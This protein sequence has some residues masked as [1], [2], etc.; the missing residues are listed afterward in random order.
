MYDIYNGIKKLSDTNKE[1]I[2]TETAALDAIAQMLVPDKD[3][4]DTEKIK[5]ISN[6][7]VRILKYNE[8]LANDPESNPEVAQELNNR[9]IKYALSSLDNL[10]EVCINYACLF[11]ALA[12]R[13]GL[14]SKQLMASAHTWNKVGEDHIDLTSLDGATFM[15][16]KD[17]TKYSLEDLFKIDYELPDYAYFVSEDRIN[18]DPLYKEDYHPEEVKNVDNNIGYVSK[19]NKSL[20]EKILFYFR[21]GLISAMTVCAFLFIMEL[22][23][24]TKKEKEEEKEYTL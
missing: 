19:E 13:V 2:R 20:R 10:D 4:S 7:I 9:P 16:G 12:N 23:E 15:I 18:N 6:Y 14:N 5:A 11:Q 24:E 1:D 3:I 22:I 17:D 8:E 21:N